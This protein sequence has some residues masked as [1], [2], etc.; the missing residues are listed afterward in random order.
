MLLSEFDYNLPQELIAQRPLPERDASR[1]L[2][3]DRKTGLVSHRT[4]RDIVGCLRPGDVLVINNTKVTPSRLVGEKVSGGKIEAL[5]LKNSGGGRYEA[6]MKS[7]LSPGAEVVFGGVI[8]ASVLEDLGGG[9]KVIQ[10]K[11]GEAAAEELSKIGRMPLPPYIGKEMRDEE[12]DRERYQTVYAAS[13][14]AVAA[15]TAGLHFTGQLLD[16]MAAAGVHVAQVTLHV[17]PGTF[18]P[19]REEIIESHVMEEEEFF[20][21]QESAAAVNAAK[22]EGRRIIA[23]GTT[24][25]R[26][27]ESAYKDGSIGTGRGITGLFIYPG[28]EFKVVDALI[29]NFHLPK[30]TLL[31]LI[32][33][34]AGRDKVMKA[35]S[36]AIRLKY[37]FYSYGD[38]MFIY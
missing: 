11:G 4:F 13:P 38:A 2:T 27:L 12:S 22:S 10:F 31:M 21:P 24:S 19:V 25:A 32:C 3:L 37:R 35:Y 16:E 36:E 7:R 15:P 28:Y 17:G 26:T 18:M 30:S 23:V 6:L 33:A 9:R 29:T 5:L 14:G 20:I 34:L 8:S 1:L